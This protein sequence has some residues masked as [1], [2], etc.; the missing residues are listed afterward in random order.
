MATAI[1]APRINNND[2]EVKVLAF[3]INIGDKIQSG[4]IVGQI[5]TDKAVLDVTAPTDG[6][7]LG[8]V[9]KPEE[10]VQVG[11]IMLWLGE[12]ADEAIPVVKDTAT[13]PPIS[14]TSQVTA[15]ARILLEDNG[16]QADAIP[17]IDGRVTVEAVERYLSTQGAVKAEA[18][19]PGAVPPV[20][21][22]PDIEGKQIDLTREEKGMASTVA[23]HRDFAVPGYIEIDYDLAPWADYARRFQEAKGLLMPP[24]LPLMA[25]R[26]VDIAQE[27]PRLNAT[28]IGNKRFEYAPVNLGFTIQAGDALYLAVVRNTTALDEYGFVNS[29][30]DVLRRAAGHNL[31]ESEASGATIGFSSMER[32]KVTR[33][34]PILPPHT[35]L[36]VAHAAGQGGRGVLGASYDHRVLNGGQVVAALKKLSSPKKTQT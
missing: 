34:I 14:T 1:Y 26:L 10:V 35:A 22:L 20:D 12:S 28:I 4:Q 18:K 5:E 2:D 25:W 36:M 9:A 29:L 15:K 11:S 30:G 27:T 16:L 6:Y 17:P 33:H 21:T 8:F 19:P 7:V 32:W 24:L 23:W 31:R 3:E 13:T